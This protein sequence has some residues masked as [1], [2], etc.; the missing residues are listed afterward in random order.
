MRYQHALVSPKKEIE[1]SNLHLFATSHQHK[2]DKE[3]SHLPKE[4]V[5]DQGGAGGLVEG[6]LE[7]LLL[8]TLLLL[9]EPTLL[10]EHRENGRE[11]RRVQVAVAVQV[12]HLERHFETA[13]GDCSAEGY[14][15]SSVHWVRKCEAQ[16][17]LFLATCAVD[18]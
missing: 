13:Q 7:A 4:D 2:R 17:G 9:P 8:K 18:Y 11:L 10:E 14:S 16:I 15:V 6:S 12:V 5:E 3:I 1:D